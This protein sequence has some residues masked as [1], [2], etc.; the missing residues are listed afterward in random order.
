[1]PGSWLW[2]RGTIARELFVIL[3]HKRADELTPA[4]S[5]GLPGDDMGRGITPEPR[6]ETADLSSCE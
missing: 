2:S 1:M 5:E 3:G 6:H 4:S